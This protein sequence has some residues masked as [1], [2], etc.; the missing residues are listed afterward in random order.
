MQPD[1]ERLT[2]PAQARPRDL[3]VE[4]RSTKCAFS[5][6]ID[7]VRTTYHG[8]GRLVTRFVLV[9]SHDS[10]LMRRSTPTARQSHPRGS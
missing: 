9:K 2:A 7:R 10:T 8:Q 1:A 6:R 4:R 5:A 3:L